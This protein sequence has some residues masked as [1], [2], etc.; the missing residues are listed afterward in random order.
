MGGVHSIKTKTDSSGNYRLD[1]LPKGEKIEIHIRPF[2]RPYFTRRVIIPNLE[3][4]ESVRQ[5]IKLRRGIW[6]TGK[7][8]DDETRQPISARVSYAPFSKNDAAQQDRN[9]IGW[10]QHHEDGH[11]W[12]DSEGNYRVVAM[13][14]PGVIRVESIVDAYPT[15]QSFDL[16]QQIE[17]REGNNRYA[18]GLTP[19]KR[20]PTAFQEINPAPEDV[21]VTC[22]F[23]LYKGQEVELVAQDSDGQVLPHVQVT[24]WRDRWGSAKEMK[25]SRFKLV[26]FQADETRS[27]IL[28]HKQSNLGKALLVSAGKKLTDEIVT[29]QPCATIA[30]RLVDAEGD[31]LA[32]Q[33]LQ[34]RVFRDGRFERII[35][36]LTT[37]N[38]GRF[39]Y[40]QVPPG[41][42]LG[43]EIY[44]SQKTLASHSFDVD[45]GESIDLGTIDV[46]SDERPAPVRKMA[47]EVQ[48]SNEPIDRNLAA[49]G[50]DTVSSEIFGQVVGSDGKPVAGAKFYWMR[51]RVHDLDPMQPRLIAVSDKSGSYR[52]NLPSLGIAEDAPARWSYLQWMVIRAPGHGFSVE[53]PSSLSRNMQD[54]QGM[55]GALASAFSGRKGVPIKLPA[56][57]KP[58]R[59][60]LVD[61]D[62]K[63]VV[64]ATVRIRWFTDGDSDAFTRR[65]AAVRDSQNVEWRARVSKLLSIIEPSPLRHALPMAKTDSN[66]RFELR[67]IGPSR[68]FQLLVEG[69]QIESTE[70]I[71]RNEPGE[72]VEVAAD[73]QRILSDFKVYPQEFLH[74][75]G[76]SKPVEGRVLD[77][78]T[79]A[80]I[81]NA[82]VRAYQI[83]GN[84]LNTS[85]ERDHYATRT[86]A[87]GKYRIAGLPIGAENKLV[88]FTSGDAPYIPVGHQI[89]TSAEGMLVSQDFQLKRGV[90]AE[91]R[92]FDQDSNKPFTGEV[93]YYYF[94]N[95]DLEKSFPGLRRAFLDG[96]YWTDRHGEFRVPVLPTRGILAFRYAGHSFDRDVI[97]SYPRGLGADSI[98]GIEDVGGL[99]SFP[100]RPHYL[101]PEDY[102]RLL[103][104]HPDGDSI[105]VRADMPLV[106]SKTVSIR[107]IDVEGKPLTNFQMYGAARM[108]GWERMKGPDFE[109]KGLEPKE[110]RKVFVY[111]RG[112]NLA[113]GVTV[114]QEDTE[115]RIDIK[116]IAAGAIR[117]R[118]VDADSVPITDAT[119]HADYERLVGD[120]DA[121][122]WFPHPELHANPT[123]IPVDKEG[124][125]ELTGIVPGKVYNA[126]ASAPRQRRGTMQDMG[127][128]RA[129]RDVVVKKGEAK[130]LG[131][132]VVSEDKEPTDTSA[133]LVGQHQTHPS[134]I[135]GQVT[136]ADGKPA[137]H[138][139]VAIIGMRIQPRRGGDHSPPDE[140]LAEGRTDKNGNYQLSFK[141]ANSKTHRFA[142]VIARTDGMALAWKQVNLDDPEMEAS[143]QI[144]SEAPIKG[145]LVDI[146]GQAAPGVQLQV[147]SVLKRSSKGSPKRDRVYY[148]GERI[149]EAWLSTVTSDDQGR[150][151]VRGIPT[152]F[153]V[154]LKVV[155]NDSFA[156]QDIALNTGI[157]EQRGTRDGTYR[158]LVKNVEPGQTA[159]LPLAP[160]QRFEGLVTYEDT[161]QPTPHARLTIW[162]SQ[163]EFGSMSLVSGKADS[164]GRYRITPEPGIRFGVTAYPPEGEP[165][166]ARKTPLDEAI[167]WADGDTSRQ[168]DV[169]L[170]RGVLVRGIVVEEGTNTPVPGASIQY[171]PETA[172]NSHTSDDIL[173]G[174]QGI[175]L[176][177]DQGEFAIAVLPGPGRLLVHGPQGK[178]VLQEI[179]GRQLVR[180]EPGG[181]RNYAHAI[182][183][184]YPEESSEPMDVTISLK[185]GET[186]TGRIVDEN[187]ISVDE[188]MIVTR[189]LVHPTSLTWRG[190][191]SPTLG[192][193]FELSGLEPDKEY[194]VH[195]LDTKRRLGATANLRASL[196]T[197]TIEL[198]PCAEAKM[199]LVDPEGNPLVDYRPGLHMVVTP[200]VSQFDYEARRRG[201]LGADED[202]VANINRSGF[203]RNGPRTDKEGRVTLLELIPGA[204]YRMYA[205]EN[206]ENR[207]L[208]QFT[209]E[210]GET[211][212]LGEFVVDW[213]D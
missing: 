136:V 23:A 45:P 59:G 205:F 128:G 41:L 114:H 145:K 143:L 203:Y 186:V 19:T 89:D 22:K 14:G 1:G 26:A 64:G 86:D 81:A 139:H 44:P 88:A 146:Q 54:S 209:V 191:S 113:G 13:P 2:E 7:V 94:P 17:Q 87:D 180:G 99:E 80:P 9:E 156:P 36:Q 120:P 164:E 141:G 109:I 138:A 76:P 70:I 202:F 50:Q 67:D 153:G 157:T 106:K 187:G 63:P 135:A 105:T 11:S 184:I 58:I 167:R 78:D 210:Y 72:I 140:V 134:V 37:D 32:N 133:E 142:N 162:A 111:H 155:G 5:D 56:A 123:N 25:K 112:R 182:S 124:R 108:W 165:Y 10:Y 212:D 200:G 43:V 6:V 71:A 33:S 85:R 121:A 159:V 102:N 34:V 38:E 27:V 125:F 190:P 48:N 163:Q 3:G 185:P 46:T 49:N 96:R 29:L 51:T 16:A 93:T 150:F 196:E 178:Y 20:S 129:F 192:G 84:R 122:I 42:P 91:G 171:L 183:K 31:P 69:A 173:T 195:F 75:L 40:S 198:K 132:L 116:L 152:G 204:T 98:D 57:G 103:E 90:W 47:A 15:G 101:T 62:G 151:T 4:F 188:V 12:T 158:P 211:L 201:E 77:L 130:D 213:N 208:K 60:R 92:V 83:H 175:H 35:A 160:A 39:Q 115:T 168:V 8:I 82:V 107:V 149:P 24:G 73:R 147:Q 131:D 206:G 126:W 197:T 65:D 169:A 74:V 30:G 21:E 148:R 207:V 95:P 174:W 176:S 119:L 194:P 104:V 199:R 193:Q 117:G 181:T 110:T 118:L 18:G 189:L 61:I 97:D 52:F 172:N 66:G 127:I 79:G 55:I 161:G 53:R 166:L 170:P 100:T 144:A 177:D 68:L 28:Y 179:A 154:S 137:A